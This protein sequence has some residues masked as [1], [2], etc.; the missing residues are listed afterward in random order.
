MLKR[1]TTTVPKPI[2]RSKRPYDS[3]LPTQKRERRKR[4]RI[5]VTQALQP[6]MC[7]LEAIQPIQQPLPSELIHLPTSV[8][9]LI[10]PIPSLHIPSE[11]L[12]IKCKLELAMTHA[13]KT[14]T[15]VGGAFVTDPLALVSLLSANSP[16]IAVGGDCGAKQTK[17]GVTYLDAGI[18]KFVCL[19]VYEGGDSWLELQD[20]R[21]TDLT[22]FE[23]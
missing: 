21:A 14:D 2:P 7:P 16:F 4:A 8:R 6:I 18:Q 22:K 5:A 15:F 13:T 19:L 23:G 12:M 10:R 17:I 20:C 1:S 11:K 3:L 9:E